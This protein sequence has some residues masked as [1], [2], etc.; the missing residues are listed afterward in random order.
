MSRRRDYLRLYLVTDRDLGRGRALV[1][2]VKTAVAGGV[3]AVQLRE[4]ELTSRAFVAEA[5][6]IAQALTGS[7]IPLF[8][9]DR[10]DVALAVGADGVHVGQDDMPYS[11]ARKV[12]GPEALIGLSVDSREQVEEAEAYDVDYLGVGAIFATPTKPD[13][14]GR[15]G[16]SGL[17]DVRRRSR[18]CLVAIGGLDASNAADVVRAGADGIAVV[19]AICSAPDPHRAARTLNQVVQ[20]AWRERAEEAQ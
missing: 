7:G 20:D 14:Q 11:L 1:D 10:V 17:A 4:K 9:N 6:T 13:A 5:R 3:T 15:W 16:I 2:V 8:I 18:H 19:S 12:L